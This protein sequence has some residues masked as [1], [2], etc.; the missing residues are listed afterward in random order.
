[1]PWVVQFYPDFTAEFAELDQ[2]VQ[3]ELMARLLVLEE[4]GPHLGRPNVD[5]L[6]GSSFT[7]MKELRFNHDG[8]W[9]FAFA[10]DQQ[11]QGIILCGGNK[12]GKQ[13]RKFYK[14]LIGIADRRFSDHLKSV[15]PSKAGK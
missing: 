9:R 10:F 13:K 7:N 12:E 11:Q 4:F 5:T 2:T 1:M 8:V 15:K 3:D 6:K 14:A